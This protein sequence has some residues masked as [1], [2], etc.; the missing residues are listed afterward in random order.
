V[1]AQH[2]PEDPYRPILGEVG[3]HESLADLVNEQD[4]GGHRAEQPDEPPGWA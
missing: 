3:H 1:E 4:C 2:R